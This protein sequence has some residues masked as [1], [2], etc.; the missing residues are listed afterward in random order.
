[1]IR[2]RQEAH[3][4][5]YGLFTHLSPEDEAVYAYIKTYE[6]ERILVLLNF[7]DSAVNC[8]VPEDLVGV[9]VTAWIGNVSGREVKRVESSA[10][11]S[12]YEGLALV[13]SI[14]QS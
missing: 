14:H 3:D 8:A 10:R 2:Y 13:C 11:L 1:M 12:A 4:Q 5:I 7:T 9:A 6:S